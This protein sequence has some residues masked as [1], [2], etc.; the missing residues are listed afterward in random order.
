MNAYH[1]LLHPA[2]KSSHGVSDAHA[3][4]DHSS[5]GATAVDSVALGNFG[6]FEYVTSGNF[7]VALDNGDLPIY[8]S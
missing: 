5:A 8:Y 7:N 2:Q 1:F 3:F 6:S 4:L